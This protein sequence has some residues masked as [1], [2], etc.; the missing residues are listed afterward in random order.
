MRCMKYPGTHAYLFR[1]TYPELKLT[2]IAKMQSIVPE[3]LGKYRASDY[4]M[5]LVN[6]SQIHFCHLSD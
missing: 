1:R 5:E 4:V 2:L 3:S 6:G